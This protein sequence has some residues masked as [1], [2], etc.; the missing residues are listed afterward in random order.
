[1]KKIAIIAFCFL[2]LHDLQAQRYG[3]KG[4][5]YWS[6]SESSNTSQTVA[7]NGIPLEVFVH[8][9]TSTAEVDIV[10]G[11]ITKIYTPVAER[12]FCKWDG[13]FKSKLPAGQYS[14]F[15]HYKDGFYGNLQDGAGN[16]SPVS[17][18]KNK[19]EWITITIN[20]SNY[21]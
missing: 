3:I 9:L 2:S 10:D 19:S 12:F 18:G 16:I 5:L 20:Y 21:H 17:L 15:V 7:Y 14:V 6:T 4:Q 1:M 11:V 13:S 8:E